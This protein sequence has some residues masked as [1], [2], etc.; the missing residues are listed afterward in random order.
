MIME[1]PG[2]ND[3]CCGSRRMSRWELKGEAAL[4]LP[5]DL[6]IRPESMV[7]Q[8]LQPRTMGRLG[9]AEVTV[10]MHQ[11]GGAGTAPGRR[12]GR[13]VPSRDGPRRE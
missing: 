5:V 11:V 13:S 12:F 8:W 7:D 6:G 1:E 9:P 2:L 10:R 3:R 4:R